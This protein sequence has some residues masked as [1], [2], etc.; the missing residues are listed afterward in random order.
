VRLNLEKD[1]I[2]HL[3]HWAAVKPNARACIFVSNQGTTVDELTYADLMKRSLAVAA[4][5]R[6]RDGSPGQRAALVFEPGLAFLVGFF[7]SILA[8][9]IAVPMSPPRRLAMRDSTDAIIANC[10]PRFVLTTSDLWMKLSGKVAGRPAW[11]GL[12]WL[13]VDDF[14]A[15]E[16]DGA[17]VRPLPDETAFL[18]YT[19]G[20]TSNPKGAVITHANLANN[21]AMMTES[22]HTSSDSVFVS[23]LPLFHDMGLIA[24]ALHAVAIGATCILMAPMTFMQRPLR[25]LRTI[26]EHKADFGGAPNFAFDHCVDRLRAADAEALNLADWRV[27]FTGAEPVRQATLERFARAFAPYGFNRRALFPC[28]GMAEATVMISGK[29]HFDDGPVIRDADGST[30]VG[31][32][33][34]LRGEEIAIVDPSSRQ[35]CA[36]LTTGYWADAVATETTFRA[37]IDGESVPWLRT[38]DLGLLDSASELFISGRIKDLIIVRGENH[39]PQD[40][41][42]TIRACHPAL[43]NQQGAAFAVAEERAEPRLVV[44]QEVGRE[45]RNRATKHELDAAIREAVFREHGLAVHQLAIVSPGSVPTTTSGKIQRSRARAIWLANE[46]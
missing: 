16:S 21:L 45:W 1:I 20:S 22:F 29:T 39:Y 35:R 17:F 32:G 24:N 2:Q 6:Q 42:F 12:E 23:W 3:F 19:S 38:G 11:N 33:S 30:I 10:L 15:Q 43:H 4:A 8:G 46:F 18:Q 26:S 31:C 14:A 13:A 34:A 36:P 28:Y 27:A 40:I 41:E 5:L 25:W 44:V 7:G 9:L 37:R